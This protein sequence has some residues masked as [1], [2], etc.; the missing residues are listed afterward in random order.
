TGAMS[1]AEYAA[2]W[3][4]VLEPGAIDILILQDGVGTGRASPELAGQYLAELGPSVEAVGV[5]L[6]SVAELFHQ[7]HGSPIDNRPFAAVP[8]DPAMLRHSLAIEAPLVEHVVAFAVLDYMDPRRG[9]AARRLYDDY[10]TTCRVAGSPWRTP[11]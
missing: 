4:E 11:C 2:W 1:P 10:T 7:L 9:G 8:I 3:L 6:W 5:E